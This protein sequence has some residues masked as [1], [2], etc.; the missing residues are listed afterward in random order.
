MFNSV[1]PLNI[2]VAKRTPM[3][4]MADE[5]ME[6]ESKLSDQELVYANHAIDHYMNVLIESFYIWEWFK[7]RTIWLTLD[8]ILEF[9]LGFADR[10]LGNQFKRNLGRR[11]EVVR[12]AWQWLGIIKATGHQFF[13]GDA[14]FPILDIDGNIVGAYGRRISPENRSNHVYYHHWI[15]GKV[16]F[17]NVKALA[18]YKRIIFCK[19]PLEALTLISA[20][21]PN[22]VST[23]GLYSFEEAHLELLEKYQPSEVVLAFDN[24]DAGNH[25]AGII[26][27]SLEAADIDCFRLPLPRNKDLNAY[28][29][30][31]E[32]P[33]TALAELS[34][35]AFPFSQ[36]Y[37]M[38]VKRR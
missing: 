10:S 13:H 3:F 6:E 34:E 31:V 26:A 27:Q 8:L 12:G 25:V 24:S 18:E 1:I 2:N 29:C 35:C 19:S 32:D 14:V 38:L 15:A 28:A 16:T 37:E 36:S 30:S 21:I 11:A 20:G 7:K 5:G 4:G 17:F 23:M 9:R 33:K 22:V